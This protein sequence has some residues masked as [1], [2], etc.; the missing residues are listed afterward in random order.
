MKKGRLLYVWV[1]L[2]L[3]IVVIVLSIKP[4]IPE[5][6]L[7]LT[8]A[9]IPSAT[10]T[11]FDPQ[12]LTSSITTPSPEIIL[13]QTFTP[14]PALQATNTECSL[15]TQSVDPYANTQP[16][17]IL[18]VYFI[19]V[20]Q[21]DSILIQSSCGETILID[22]GEDNQK[23]LNFI[24]SLGI[25]KL[26]IVIASH[27]HPD[28]IGGLIEV[29]NT[30]PVAKVYSNGEMYSTLTYE[31]FVDA[32]FSSNAAYFEV[33]RGDTITDGSLTLSV[34]NLPYGNENN[35]NNNSIILR[36]VYQNIS[37]LFMG[38][39]EYEVESSLVN[40]GF[41]IKSDILKIGHHGSNTSSSAIF[42]DSVH[43]SIAVYSAG[44]GNP[45]HLPDPVVL[46]RISGIGT[47]I[48]GTDING[49]ILISTDSTNIQVLTTLQSEPITIP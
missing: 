19:D 37:F 8:N 47:V 12:Y 34:L 1:L 39:A 21:G 14:F 20:G 7:A 18:N 31:S 41:S 15:P 3:M 46:R 10:N 24:L 30:I 45:Y 2:W 49:T 33:K 38:D 13:A 4:C 23:A 26:D 27:V 40:S 28:H 32:I 9:L 25:T 42:L 36:L 44:L 6:K 5:K 29:L 43:P 17:Q 48:Y 35:A 11:S 22:G 16:T